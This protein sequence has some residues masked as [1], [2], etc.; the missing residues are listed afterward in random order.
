MQTI[1]VGRIKYD[2]VYK[3]LVGFI[4]LTNDLTEEKLLP[5]FNQ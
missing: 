5:I 4:S 1:T 3:A 2:V